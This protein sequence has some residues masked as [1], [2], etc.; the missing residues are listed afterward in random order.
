MKQFLAGCVVA[1]TISGLLQA[2]LM[3]HA[4]DVPGKNI[5]A[6]APFTVVGDQGQ[7]L[8]DLTNGANGPVLT[9]HGRNAT[10]T[11]M[12]GSTSGGAAVAIGTGGHRT[13]L[14]VDNT[15]SGVFTAFNDKG[16]WMKAAADEQHLLV[17][18]DEVR[19]V[20]LGVKPGT[21]SALRIGAPD[22]TIVANIGSNV[23]AGGAGAMF[24]G[25][26]QSVQAVAAV[27]DQNGNGRVAV[28]IAGQDVAALEPNVNNT[29]GKVSVADSS[30]NLVFNAGLKTDGNG[31]ACTFA[32]AS[33]GQ[34]C[35]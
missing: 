6:K 19:V 11:V 23:K 7:V 30:G 13:S 25:N 1:A 4:Q 16:V 33:G 27:A 26:A 9:I 15:Y 22:G 3:V 31:A 21:N 32:L 2:T 12:I 10:Q 20:D 18:T 14:E 28:K 8:M 29:G 24:I 34:K 5:V 17:G 35:M